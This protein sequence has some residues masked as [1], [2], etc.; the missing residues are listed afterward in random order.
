MLRTGRRRSPSRRSTLAPRGR[1]GRRRA[2]DRDRVVGPGQRDVHPPR[3][4]RRPLDGHEGD[5]S[6]AAASRS[7]APRRRPAT[8]R[9]RTARRRARSTPSRRSRSVDVSGD[10]EPEVIVNLYSGGA[11]CCEIALVLRWTGATSRRPR[12]ALA[13][14]G[15]TPRHVGRRG[16]PAAIRPRR[17][18]ASPTSTRRSPT[19]RSRC[20]SSPS[21]A[22]PGRTR[23]AHTRTR[24]APTPRAGSRS[25]TSAATGAGRWAL[26]AAWVADQYV[27][28][29]E[30]K[31]DRFLAHELKAGRLTSMTP[32]PGGKAYIKLLKKDLK[33]WGYVR[34]PRRDAVSARPGP[35]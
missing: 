11:H 5:R 29:R 13:D 8:A 19:R 22:A 4:R 32:W 9:R 34:A 33:K 31:A 2:G 17:T 23:P 24:C 12:A 30:T 35:R 25:T 6:C 1:A 10:G 18:R 7:T 27:L 26:L 15:Y 20:R 3:R 14:F 16:V 21:S 28:G